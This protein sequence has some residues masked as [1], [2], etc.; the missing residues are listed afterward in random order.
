MKKIYLLIILISPLFLQAQVA[1]SEVYYDTPYLE[2][3]E[4]DRRSHAGEFIELY[5]YSKE[6]IDISGWRLSDNTGG[7]NFPEGTIIKSNDYLVV[8]YK[9]DQNLNFFDLFSNTSED[10]NGDKIIYQRNIILNN[11]D[12]RVIL[13][14]NKIKEHNLNKFYIS[15]LG[16]K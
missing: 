13:W 15:C 3:L 2:R 11:Y 9:D 8:A 16:V 10:D 6:D 4:L 5:N 7:F 14:A 12:D 1:I